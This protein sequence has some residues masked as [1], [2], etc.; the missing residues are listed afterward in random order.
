MRLEQAEPARG[1]S[2]TA[3]VNGLDGP[4]LADAEAQVGKE[5]GA[6]LAVAGQPQPVAAW[7]IAST[8]AVD[9]SETA[10]GQIHLSDETNLQPFAAGKACHFLGIAVLAFRTD[11]AVKLTGFNPA[12]LARSRFPRGH[13]GRRRRE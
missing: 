1:F 10:G 13:V 7:A 11:D 9:D 2:A 5:A 8:A 4:E 6:D 12:R 3:L